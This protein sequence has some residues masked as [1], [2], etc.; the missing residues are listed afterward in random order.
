MDCGRMHLSRCVR[1]TYRDPHNKTFYFWVSTFCER[2]RDLSLFG[3]IKRKTKINN[4]KW[5]EGREWVRER[6]RKARSPMSHGAKRGICW[7]SS[8]PVYPSISGSCTDFS[9][10]FVCLSKLC[11]MGSTRPAGVPL[12]R[13]HV[14][15]VYLKLRTKFL[16]PLYNLENLP[17]RWKS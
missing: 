5:R 10:R 3:L 16:H 17:S 7:P 14:I 8:S 2:L 9:H 11:A 12:S 4:N 15:N 13:D 1:S 6:E